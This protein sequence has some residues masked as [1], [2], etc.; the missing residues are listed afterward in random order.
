[1]AW[2]PAFSERM[3]GGGSGGYLYSSPARAVFS[4]A[5][6]PRD[7]G[8]LHAAVAKGGS[9]FAGERAVS[10]TAEKSAAAASTVA[11]GRPAAGVGRPIL[12]YTPGAGP[13]TII[14]ID[15]S[16]SMSADDMPGGKT[17]LDVAKRRADD[18]VGTLGR[19]GAA[20]VIAF[21]DSAE[22]LAPFTTDVRLLRNV[23]D[24]I[25]PTD[26][27]TK[28]EAAYQL[29]NA[30]A[31]FT[32]GDSQA[33]RQRRMFI[34]FPMDESWTATRSACRE[35]CTTSKSAPRR[36][37][38]SLLSRERSARLPGAD[39]S[40]GF[41]PPGEFR[42]RSGDGCAGSVRVDGRVRSSGKV[43][44][45]PERFTDDQRRQAIA[46]GIPTAR[47]H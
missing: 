12:N 38:T 1:M 44:L 23:I 45:L 39:A 11:I 27:R 41:R 6:P 46:G 8:P 29:A 35:T 4:Q 47:R 10:A 5:S 36:R 42:P 16:A 17:R 7:A 19:N 43:N 31:A 26:R 28:L 2:F 40:A 20:M 33:Y 9:G 37:G 32:A 22:T 34:F 18:L 14:L 3:G 21:D 24:L 13:R 30:Q 15:R 25:Q